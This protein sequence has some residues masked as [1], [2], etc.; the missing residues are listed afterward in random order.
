[1]D[2]N[3]LASVAFPRSMS[4]VPDLADLD[5]RERAELLARV[6]ERLGR[7]F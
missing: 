7:E 6:L 2:A 3:D 5:V 4:S 1:M